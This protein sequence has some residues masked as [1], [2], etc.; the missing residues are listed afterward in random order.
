MLSEK[1]L[2]DGEH[3]VVGRMKE[4]IA[5]LVNVV[6]SS[7]IFVT[8]SLVFCVGI[9]PL[10]RAEEYVLHK[11]QRAIDPPGLC[12]ST[13]STVLGAPLFLA[14]D[15]IAEEYCHMEYGFIGFSDSAIICQHFAEMG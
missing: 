8:V 11:P 2:S 13:S 12:F 14:F 9:V 4:Y 3:L 15:P 7:G 6:Y 1:Y 10:Q 5:V